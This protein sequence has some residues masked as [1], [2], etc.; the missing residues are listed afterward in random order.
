MP[1]DNDKPYP[2]ELQAQV[3]QDHVEH[4]KQLLDKPVTLT[5]GYIYSLL[6]GFKPE[7][8]RTIEYVEVP[9]AFA[10]FLKEQ[11]PEQRWITVI[12]TEIWR[13]VA[14]KTSYKLH[15]F[16]RKKAIETAITEGARLDTHAV[17]FK[18]LRASGMTVN[19]AERLATFAS[20]KP[21]NLKLIEPM[22]KKP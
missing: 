7:A 12:D 16:K 17:I 13:T 4:N 10:L 5:L 21:E 15:V 18:A 6:F 8:E 19:H 1:D 3:L 14:Y 9:L 11:D 20:L 22:L 2:H